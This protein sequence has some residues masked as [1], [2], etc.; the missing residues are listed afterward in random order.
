M[1]LLF[2]ITGCALKPALITYVYVFNPIDTIDPG[3]RR[4]KPV[5]KECLALGI[6]NR[7]HCFFIHERIDDKPITTAK[8]SNF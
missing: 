6:H 5:A 3:F 2:M 4:Q 7:L 8:T 1:F